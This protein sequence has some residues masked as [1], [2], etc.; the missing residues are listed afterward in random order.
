MERIIYSLHVELEKP[1]KISENTGRRD[2]TGV[3]KIKTA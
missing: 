1:W 2:E 3:L